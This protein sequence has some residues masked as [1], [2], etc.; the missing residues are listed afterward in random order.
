MRA[1][2]NA[3]PLAALAAS[4]AMLAV[5]HGF[6]TFGH[7][8]PCHLCLKQREAYWAAMALAALFSVLWLAGRRRL[9]LGAGGVVLAAAFLYGAYWAGFQAGAEWKW[10]PA[11]ESCASAGPVSAGAMTAFLRGTGGFSGPRCDQASWVFLALSMAGWNFLVSLGL[12]KLSLFS[13]FG[14]RKAR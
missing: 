13:A 7:L 3:W 9:A 2:L 14:A 8:A 5:A 12:A 11:P 1:L 4:A 6:Q 10:W